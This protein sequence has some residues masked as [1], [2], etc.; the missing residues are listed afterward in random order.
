VAANSLVRQARAAEPALH[1]FPFN[2]RCLESGIHAGEGLPASLSGRAF[3][4]H[5]S[6]VNCPISHRPHRNAHQASDGGCGATR[7]QIVAPIQPA[8]ARTATLTGWM[9]HEPTQD[10]VGDGLAD[11]HR[12]KVGACHQPGC[13]T[14]QSPS[15][16][17]CDT[18][19][20]VA[21]E[22]ARDGPGTC[23]CHDASERWASYEV[24]LRYTARRAAPKDYD[25]RS[26]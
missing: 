10:G 5:Y 19:R 17:S 1:R 13:S 2:L 14:R 4:D 24:S 25:Q 23:P 20:A 11:D 8:C 16:A 6:S 7:S 26:R 21:L 3:A 22:R 9:L 12:T 15:A 18:R